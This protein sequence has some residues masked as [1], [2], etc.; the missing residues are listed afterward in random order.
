MILNMLNYL[1]PYIAL[2][3]RNP[4]RACFFCDPYLKTTVPI[5]AI[6][7]QFADTDRHQQKPIRFFYMF[8]HMYSLQKS[9]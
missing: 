4:F 7:K 2:G 8:N 5:H 6:T 9:P 3:G 1:N